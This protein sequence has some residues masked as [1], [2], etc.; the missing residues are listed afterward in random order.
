[1]SAEHSTG[2]NEVVDDG[3]AYP[4]DGSEDNRAVDRDAWNSGKK[5]VWPRQ[6]LYWNTDWSDG[7]SPVHLHDHKGRTALHIAVAGG[8]LS[9]V[10]TLLAN[11]ADMLARTLADETVI[12]IAARHDHEKVLFTLLENFCTAQTVHPSLQDQHTPKTMHITAKVHGR[13]IPKVQI[14]VD[15]AELRFPELLHPFADATVGPPV[16][17][18]HERKI[19]IICTEEIGQFVIVDSS[20]KV[21]TTIAGGTSQEW[22]G[23][24]GNGSYTYKWTPKQTKT[25]ML[26]TR[27]GGGGGGNIY[28]SKPWEPLA[29]LIVDLNELETLDRYVLNFCSRMLFDHTPTSTVLLEDAIRSHAY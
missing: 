4:G 13:E 10:Q 25:G 19:N 12:H 16:K 21:A 2:T 27:N 9:V 3:S 15:D 18:F 23:I 17:L 11:G 5:K 29:D 1:V 22:A 20:G 28:V 7:D 14:M 6:R 8:S 24:A 26:N